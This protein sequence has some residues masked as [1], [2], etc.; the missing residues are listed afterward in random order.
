MYVCISIL[1]RCIYICIYIY[2]SHENNDINDTDNNDAYYTCMYIYVYMYT[3][4]RS[5]EV[6]EFLD[7]GFMYTQYTYYDIYIYIY[8]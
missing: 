3:P 5:T 8:V 6:P 2:I 4:S 1:Y 7:Q